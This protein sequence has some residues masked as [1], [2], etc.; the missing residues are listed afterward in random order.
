MLAISNFTTAHGAHNKTT[1][2]PRFIASTDMCCR[3][4]HDVTHHYKFV[5]CVEL[6]SKDFVARPLPLL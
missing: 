1:M 6:I 5:E 4:I 3:K 2:L